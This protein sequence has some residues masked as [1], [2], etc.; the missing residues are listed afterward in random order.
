MKRST[1]FRHPAKT[2]YGRRVYRP[3]IETL[4]DRLPPGDILLGTPWGGAC[5]LAL[6]RRFRT[7]AVAR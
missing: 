2:V 3:R 7:R 5:A 1:L 4:E 6:A